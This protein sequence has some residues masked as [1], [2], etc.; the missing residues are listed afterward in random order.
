MRRLA[1][2]LPY[3]YLGALSLA[4][5]AIFLRATPQPLDDHFLY[6]Q[7]IEALASGRLDLSIPGF[8][9][10]DFFA[11]PL[12]WL[13]HSPI[14]QIYTLMLWGIALP[15]L[16]F[17]AGRALARHEEWTRDEWYGLALASVIAMMPFVNFVALRGWTGPGYWGLMLLT[18]WLGASKR[19]WLAGIFF[20]LAILTKPFALVLLPLLLHFAWT[21]K[22][23]VWHRQY[24]AILIGLGIAAL[25]A[26]IQILQAG[27]LIVGAHMD[28]TT[29]TVWQGPTRIALNLAHSLQ[30]LFSV[31]NYYYPDPSKTGPGNMMHTSPILIFL[32]LFALL[33]PKDFFDKSRLP[34]AL[35]I[36]A[37]FGIGLNALLDHMDHFYMEA[38]VLLLILASLPALKKHPLW[39]PIA[40]A[41]LHFQVFYFYLQYRPGFGLDRWFFLVPAIVD[42]AVG[43][44]FLWAVQRRL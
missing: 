15:F 13:T 24:S 22:R 19:T 12:Y 16:A 1:S 40:L 34:F 18:I 9:G 26:L 36:G 10:T 38:S 27:H 7:F 20:G 29:T 2:S 3:L 30:I 14:I 4:I 17:L 5:A 21:G 32:G 43:I 28:V 42:I 11:V 35:L 6:Q 31:H 39:I 33:S 41:T 25:Y 44:W 23:T 8:H 37:L